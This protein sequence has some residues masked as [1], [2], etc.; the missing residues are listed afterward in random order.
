[1]ESKRSKYETPEKDDSQ[2]TDF[3]A[4]IVNFSQG[5]SF[6]SPL[7][8]STA[9]LN[10]TF[11]FPE[12]RE[13]ESQRSCPQHK[14]LEILI[15]KLQA[16]DLNLIHKSSR[17]QLFSLLG[18]SLK[19]ELK[20]EAELYRHPDSRNKVPVTIQSS[21]TLKLYK[22]EE[23]LIF[24]E[25]CTGKSGR[26]DEG[27]E[28]TKEK[29]AAI[30]STFYETLL[31]G[32]NLLTIGPYTLQTTN[33]VRNQVHSRAMYGP[34]TGS[35][36]FY[37]KHFVPTDPI[38]MKWSGVLISDNAQRGAC[39]Y[40]KH[41][42]GKLDRSIPVN[43]CTHN[44][45]AISSDES[46]EN[47]NHIFRDPDVMPSNNEFHALFRPVA[48][49]FIEVVLDR[50]EKAARKGR[51]AMNKVLQQ[52]IEEAWED[53][54]VGMGKTAAE[55]LCERMDYGI[56]ERSI[57]CVKCHNQQIYQVETNNICVRCHNNPTYFQRNEVG[58]YKCYG[59]KE[60]FTN[61]VIIEEQEPL[62]LNPSSSRNLYQRYKELKRDYWPS[63]F[64]SI[65]IYGDGLPCISYERIKMD[66]VQCLVHDEL[67]QLR[68]KEKLEEHCKSTCR[69]DWPLKDVYT[70]NGESHEEIA[71]LVVALSASINFGVM[72]MLEDL[73][74]HSRASQLQAIKTKRLHTL[75]ELNFIFTKG[76]MT[77]CM[78][79]F[80]NHCAD[81]KIVPNVSGLYQYVSASSNLKYQARFRA[82]IDLNLPCIVNR[83]GIRLNN[84]EI[85]SGASGLFFPI[86]FAFRQ[87][88]YRDF[89]HMKFLNGSF[90]DIQERIPPADMDLSKFVSPDCL[91][92]PPELT[93]YPKKHPMQNI[94]FGVFESRYLYLTE[95][96][97]NDSHEGG[98]FVQENQL[99]RVM[100][101]LAAG[102]V[103]N[104]SVFAQAVRKSQIY[105]D[106]QRS[107]GNLGTE[108]KSPRP[109]YESE[110]QSLA[111]LV[112][113]KKEYPDAE[114]GLE[115]LH[116]DVLHLHAVGLSNYREFF[117]SRIQAIPTSQINL[118]PA[119]LTKTAHAD[120]F[121]LENQTK[122]QI[123]AKI[124]E[125]I[126]RT[127]FS[128]DLEKAYFSSRVLC[129]SIRKS[130]LLELYN[131]LVEI[132]AL[133]Y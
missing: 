22:I 12:A 128:D 87:T 65:P 68:D 45:R 79:P 31:K 13:I 35:Y 34:L 112:L 82:L 97:Q 49:E 64:L 93:S 17:L 70:I 69:L 91:T 32:A 126:A 33:A 25:S 120:Y 62:D 132:I 20:K 131:D 61:T 102:K 94:K 56:S 38:P 54:E 51:H 9:N 130:E 14:S 88:F 98:D 133:T 21:E 107:Q 124:Q 7:Q 2:S 6:P 77:A 10:R 111:A 127:E 63:D 118:K 30:Q 59:L 83:L 106:S 123:V 113:Y 73:G 129:R 26:V 43:V 76:S 37:Q 41:A 95:S 53:R 96:T 58:P 36:N 44:I 78:I 122:A 11:S 27:N 109:K 84:P 3:S 117:K 89:Y 39:K 23:L 46:R 52:W 85:A 75:Y 48:G 114:C 42:F 81:K 24:F 74:R 105:T 16:S 29:V 99:G 108:R 15:P 8:M 55:K 47:D 92:N 115:D 1:M 90:S 101:F 110:V 80:L 60:G 103:F 125:M 19:S 28:V 66:S 100:P 121:K 57:I 50:Q 116:E 71:M 18:Q 86:S 40:Q 4:E 67:I 104:N 72:E 5:S 119:F